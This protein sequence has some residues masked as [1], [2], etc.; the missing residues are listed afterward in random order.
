MHELTSPLEPGCEMDQENEAIVSIP[1]LK[2]S[3]TGQCRIAGVVK[4][5][6]GGPGMS[7]VDQG[8]P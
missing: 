6:D 2:S 1:L 3:S 8:Y 4:G 7:L 5:W